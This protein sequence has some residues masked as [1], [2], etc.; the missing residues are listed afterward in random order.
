MI[1][2]LEPSSVETKIKLKPTFIFSYVSTIQ[3]IDFFIKIVWVPELIKK[4]NY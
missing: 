1:S 3:E 4:T 2:Y